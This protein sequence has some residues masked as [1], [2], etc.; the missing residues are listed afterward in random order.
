MLADATGGFLPPVV[1]AVAGGA[2]GVASADLNEDGHLDLVIV[3]GDDDE[4]ALQTSVALGDGAGGFGAAVEVVSGAL[5]VFPDVHRRKRRRAPGPAD[6][7]QLQHLCGQAREWRRWILGAGA[8]RECVYYWPTAGDVNGDGRPDIVTGDRTGQLNVFLNNC[9]GAATNL[10]VAVT[11]SPDPV[12]EG[13][14]VTYTVTVTNQTAT[15]ATGVTLRSVLSP[16]GRRRSG[17]AQRQRDRDHVVG[18]R[19]RR[20]PRRAAPTRGRCP[21]WRGTAPPR[22]SSSSA[23]SAARRCSSRAASRATG[24]R[25]T[26]RTTPRSASTTV[27]TVGRTI[28]VTT[29]ADSGPGSLRQA[30]NRVQQ[31]R[32]RRRPHRVQHSAWRTADD[33]P[34]D[35]VA[36]DHAA[37]DHRRDHAAGVQRRADHRVERQRACTPTGS[38]IGGGNTTVRGLVINRFGQSGIFVFGPGGGNVIEGNYIGLNADRHALPSRTTRASRSSRLATEWAARRP[39]RETSFRAT[40]RAASRS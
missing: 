25:P 4:P 22:S 27:A 36:G 8:V 12:N 11:E 15:P 17:R 35:A 38:A 2:H 16:A 30:I 24:L 1:H 5:R 21:R 39:R 37:G 32:G 31:R 23:R 18:S 26:R 10:S 13:D 34:A 29:T 33:H 28:E 9:G 6:D 40:R 20:W 3:E 7:L 19:W 14:E